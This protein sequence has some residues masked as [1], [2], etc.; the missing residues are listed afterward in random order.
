VPKTIYTTDFFKVG[1]V[2]KKNYAVPNCLK[3]YAM[4]CQA[5]KAFQNFNS[6]TRCGSAYSTGIHHLGGFQWTGAIKKAKYLLQQL[7]FKTI[8][9][10]MSAA[11][12][13]P[14]SKLQAEYHHVLANCLFLE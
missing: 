5:T 6:P 1:I 14:R 13:N 2:K 7:V 8:Y 4:K 11:H 10:Y 12:A 3:S 9:V